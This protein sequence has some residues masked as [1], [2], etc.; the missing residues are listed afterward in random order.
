MIIRRFNPAE[1]TKREFLSLKKKYYMLSHINTGEKSS[2]DYYKVND[3]FEWFQ[4]YMNSKL[5]LKEVDDEDN[6]RVIENL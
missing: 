4:S 6:I 2:P 5:F 1:L 3:M